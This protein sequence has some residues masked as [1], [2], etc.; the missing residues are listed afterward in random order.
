MYKQ[1]ISH[2]LYIAVF[3]P[4]LCISLPTDTSRKPKSSEKES[5]MYAFTTRSKMEADIKS[6]RYLEFGDYDGNI[7]GTKIDSI[8]EVVEAGRICILDVNPQ[9]STTAES[10]LRGGHFD[11]TVTL[12]F[13][14]SLIDD[15]Q[16]LIFLNKLSVN[17]NYCDNYDKVCRRTIQIKG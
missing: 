8:H 6:G 15:L 10:S 17:Y 14:W 4:V 5:L 3:I 13:R 16:M 2:T 12:T 11:S 7:Y 1:C 9:V